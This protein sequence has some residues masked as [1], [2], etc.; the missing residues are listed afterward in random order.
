MK[1][2]YI[3]MRFSVGGDE[4][5]VEVIHRPVSVMRLRVLPD[6]SLQVTA[7]PGADIQGF[8][9]RKSGWVMRKREEVAAIAEACEGREDLLLLN[10][11]YYT[12][13]HGP[14]CRVAEET[15]SVTYTTPQR[16]RRH[17]VENLRSDLLARV[18]RNAERMGVTHGG[19]S[20]RAQKTRWASCSGRS[21]LSFNLA[22]AALPDI[23][24]EYIVI[25]E[26]A[27]LLHPDHSRRFWGAVGEFY[28]GVR[29]ADRELKKY[30]IFI[31]RNRCWAVLRQ[32]GEWEHAFRQHIE[33]PF[34]HPSPADAF[35]PSGTLRR[36]EPG[37]PV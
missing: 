27:H 1:N 16:L 20:V 32:V 7:P 34:Q 36:G 35:T 31:G 14:A 9:Q 19:I 8:I 11:R 10:G 3:G 15:G 17:L 24:K 22:I 12:L 28:P 29:Q 18:E 5:D 2:S 4:T 33:T 6:G 25:H 23:L 26:L 30:W 13:A 21:H 37:G